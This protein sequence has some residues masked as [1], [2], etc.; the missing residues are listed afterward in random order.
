MVLF[1]TAFPV[2][3]SQ[4]HYKHWHAPNQQPPFAFSE[5]A[6]MIHK[7][8]KKYHESLVSVK[9]GFNFISCIYFL[10]FLLATFYLQ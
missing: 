3:H 4:L 8:Q 5:F 10:F 7:K 6:F 9:K 1:C 2:K